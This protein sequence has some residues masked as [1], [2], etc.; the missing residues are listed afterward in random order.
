VYRY[1]GDEFAL[2][3]P[4][5]DERGAL[6]VAAKVLAAVAGPL[7]EEAGPRIT[8]SAGVA[9]YPADG[10]DPASIVLAAD[11]ACYA[12]KRLGRNRLS[13]AADGLRY[14]GELVATN[15]TPVDAIA[16]SDGGPTGES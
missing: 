14:A 7:R 2:L 5:T 4:R 6:S 3:L 11:R 12:S 1:G 15:P 13:P 16:A 9:T 8:C 10:T